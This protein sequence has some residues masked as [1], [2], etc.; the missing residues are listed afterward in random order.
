MSHLY[1]LTPAAKLPEI[2]EG[3]L[4]PEKSREPDFRARHVYLSADIPHALGYADHHGEGH[5]EHALLRVAEDSLDEGHL[6]PD[7]VDLPD[8]IEDD[9][10]DRDWQDIGWQESLDLSGQCTCS[11][12]IPAEKLE[13]SFDEGATW[14]P[15]REIEPASRSS[16]A[17]KR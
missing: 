12:A 8:I 1:H 16:A 3:G 15:L 2:L 7:D 4:D 6:G 13:V 11:V 14:Q 5:T 9:D 17:M 10:D